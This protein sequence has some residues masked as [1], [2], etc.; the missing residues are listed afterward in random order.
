MGLGHLTLVIHT[1]ERNHATRTQPRI[2]QHATL[3]FNMSKNSSTKSH[4]LPRTVSGPLPVMPPPWPKPI[5]IHGLPRRPNY[6]PILFFVSPRSKI[7]YPPKKIG[8]HT[9]TKAN[10][11]VFPFP[12]PCSSNSNSSCGDSQTPF[13]QASGS[14]RK[15]TIPLSIH[16]PNV[17][18]I[19]PQH[20]SPPLQTRKSYIHMHAAHLPTGGRTKTVR[21]PKRKKCRQSAGSPRR[22][23]H[24]DRIRF[25]PS[26]LSSIPHPLSSILE[27]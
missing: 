21:V 14:E 20:A 24:H 12:S 26:A 1:Q 23:P 25:F 3:V 7:F 8:G 15:R 10:L 17:R 18:L 22:R 27:F 2:A 5:G 9:R 6:S 19:H 4:R 16:L 13:R 11:S